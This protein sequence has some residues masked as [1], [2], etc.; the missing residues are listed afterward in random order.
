[1][2]WQIKT[3]ELHLVPGTWYVFY[4]KDV[5]VAIMLKWVDGQFWEDDEG[6]P[7]GD[8]QFT[9]FLKLDIPD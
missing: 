9:H 7:Y 5:D 2:R 6:F 1:M 3:D 4:N 8:P